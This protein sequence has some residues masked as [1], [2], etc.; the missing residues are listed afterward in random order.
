ML[1]VSAG[2]GGASGRWRR[3]SSHGGASCAIV[4]GAAMITMTRRRLGCR[5]ND[6]AE[7]MTDTTMAVASIGRNVGTDAAAT[8][9][10]MSPCCPA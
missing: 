4:G 10:V 8:G 5:N 1:V 2:G 9:G 3:D 7:M 6:N